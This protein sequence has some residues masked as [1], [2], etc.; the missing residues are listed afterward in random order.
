MSELRFGHGRREDIQRVLDSEIAHDSR[1]LM[2]L[3]CSI[4]NVIE[5]SD[6]F[7]VGVI[8]WQRAGRGKT[9]GNSAKPLPIE[10]AQPLHGLRYNE[11]GRAHV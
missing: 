11:I 2:D 9:H 7:E 3:D 6:E 1:Q 4:G 8:L 5:Y 10:R